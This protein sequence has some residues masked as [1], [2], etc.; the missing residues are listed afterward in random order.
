MI[1]SAQQELFSIYKV[2]LEKGGYRVFEDFLPPENTK[3]PFI[4]LG[5]VVQDEKREYKD[6][7]RNGRISIRIHVYTDQIRKRG[8]LSNIVSAINDVAV[9]NTESSNFIYQP[10]SRSSSILSDNTTQTPL[11]HGVVFLNVNYYLK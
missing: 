2:K 10:V 1:A 5:E 9:T 8:D 4:F 7:T 11:L 6:N 3:Y